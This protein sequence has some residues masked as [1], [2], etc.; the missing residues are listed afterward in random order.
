MRLTRIY[1]LLRLFRLFKIAKTQHIS[2]LINSK[3]ALKFKLNPSK[4]QIIF[5]YRNWSD[6]KSI[7]YFNIFCSFIRVF[8]VPSSQIQ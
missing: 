2:D 5:I 7:N 8:L 1:R 4:W 3:L 6:G